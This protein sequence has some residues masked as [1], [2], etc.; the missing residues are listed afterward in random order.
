MVAVNVALSKFL[1]IWEDVTSLLEE[2]A[3]YSLYLWRDFKCN[4]SK[5]QQ[6]FA[7]A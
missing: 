3:E 2:E 5:S 1:L 6:A 4:P 7:C